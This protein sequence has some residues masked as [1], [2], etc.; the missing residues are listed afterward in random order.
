MKILFLGELMECANCGTKR[1][2][3]PHVESDWTGVEMD[4][5][6]IYFCPEC[7]HGRK[8]ANQDN[9]SQAIQKQVKGA[10]K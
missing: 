9:I 1:K 4:E 7:W 3:D 10:A 2:S 6:L 8:P 5:V